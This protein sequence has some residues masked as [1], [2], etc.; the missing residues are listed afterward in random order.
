MLNVLKIFEA[1]NKPLS[2]KM[3]RIAIGTNPEKYLESILNL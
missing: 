3:K 2:L 1:G